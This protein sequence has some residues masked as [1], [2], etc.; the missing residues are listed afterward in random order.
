[1]LKIV[2]S[3]EGVIAT[4]LP[5]A[6]FVIVAAPSGAILPDEAVQLGGGVLRLNYLFPQPSAFRVLAD[7]A[8]LL[9]RIDDAAGHGLSYALAG[10]AEAIPDQTE[11]ILWHARPDGRVTAFFLSAAVAGDPLLPVVTEELASRMPDDD[12]RFAFL[13]AA[14]AG[15]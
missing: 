1:M 13:A 7:C 8:K 12:R 4:P 5:A 3:P 15:G 11:D 6:R 2:H 10:H 9:L 14:L